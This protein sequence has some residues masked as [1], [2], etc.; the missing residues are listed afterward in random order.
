MSEN[1]SS[2][3]E[4]P[5]TVSARNK[6]HSLRFTFAA[7]IGF[8][9]GASLVAGLMVNS[10]SA[11]VSKEN[12]TGKNPNVVVAEEEAGEEKKTPEPSDLSEKGDELDEGATNADSGTNEEEQSSGRFLDS[13]TVS[14][15][16]QEKIDEALGLGTA[17]R[18]SVVQ[19]FF[20]DETG[21]ENGIGTGFLVEPDVI[22]TNDHV[23]DFGSIQSEI[24]V[25]TIDGEVM[26]GELI[27]TDAYGD[28]A[29]VRLPKPL[30]AKVLEV[31]RKLVEEGE[32]VIAV[33]HPGRIGNW[34]IMAGVVASNGFEYTQPSGMQDRIYREIDTSMPTSTGASGSAITT[35]DGVVVAIHSRM[36]GEEITDDD[37]KAEEP[38]VHTYIPRIDRN[39]GQSSAGIIRLAEEA[40]V[41]LQL[42]D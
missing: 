36:A 7:S 2:A 10:N 34:A 11:D 9:L 17:M 18:A 28:V 42:V 1:E 19:V 13:G 4:Y 32:P 8:V 20:R 3:A 21:F 35:L 39:G 31:S 5:S 15:F 22:A 12:S 38:F 27:K 37:W 29:F 30:D 33:G 25:R 16:P 26:T 41:E 6:K 23:I 40:G 24:Y 14:G